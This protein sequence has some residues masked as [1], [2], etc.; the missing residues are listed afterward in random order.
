MSQQAAKRRRA[1]A[2]NGFRHLAPQQ[3]PHYKHSRFSDIHQA[4]DAER[5]RAARIAAAGGKKKK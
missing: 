1:Q 5:R 3:R 4:I 2:K